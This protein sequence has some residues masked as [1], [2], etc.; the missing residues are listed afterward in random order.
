MQNI[1]KL[2]LLVCLELIESPLCLTIEAWTLNRFTAEDK[3]VRNN[4]I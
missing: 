2:L 3:I 1:C 4:V